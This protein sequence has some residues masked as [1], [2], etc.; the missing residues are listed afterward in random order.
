MNEN[1]EREEGRALTSGLDLVCFCDISSLD[2]SSVTAPSAPYLPFMRGATEAATGAGGAA[3]HFS[4]KEE[5]ELLPSAESLSTSAAAE[6]DRT[7][8]M[9]RR[10][11]EAS[12]GMELG[13]VEVLGT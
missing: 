3:K 11:K 4:K 10:R 8:K 5:E 1:K 2:F 13:G 12:L 9:R 6:E 7:R